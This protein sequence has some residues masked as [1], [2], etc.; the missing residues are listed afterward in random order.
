MVKERASF[1]MKAMRSP[2][3]LQMLVDTE[4]RRTKMLILGAAVGIISVCLVLA[5]LYF[6]RF[7]SVLAI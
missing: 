5:A 4:T 3:G 2:M 1:V 7:N 6:A